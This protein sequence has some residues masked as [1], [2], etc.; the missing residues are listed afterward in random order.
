MVINKHQS[1]L[2]S[3]RYRLRKRKAADFCIFILCQLILA[4]AIKSA[5]RIQ[6]ITPSNSLSDL[7]FGYIRYMKGLTVPNPNYPGTFVYSSDQ[8]TTG[9]GKFRF[10]KSPRLQDFPKM[11]SFRRSSTMRLLILT[12]QAQTTGIG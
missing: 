8:L 6:E 2:W 9:A 1:I 3:D 4:C 12:L 10:F 11:L 7:D 5:I